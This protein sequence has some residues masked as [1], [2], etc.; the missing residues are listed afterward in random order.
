MSVA[1][2]RWRPGPILPRRGIP[3]ALLFWVIAAAAFVAGLAAIGCLVA[4]RATGDWREQV[5]GSATVVVRASGLESPD[6]AAARAA[7]TLLGLQGVSAARTL[8]STAFDEVI[9]RLIAGPPTAAESEPPRLLAAAFNSR[10]PATADDLARAL[11]ADGLEAAVDDHGL[12][13]SP[14]LRAAALTV[15]AIIALVAVIGAAI[16]AAVAAATRRGLARTHELA[17]LLRILGAADGFIAGLFE[18]R[19]ARAAAWAGGAGAIAAA[20]AAAAWRLFGSDQGMIAVSAPAW[21][22]LAAAAPAALI[23]ALIGAAAARLTARST[24]K[25]L[26]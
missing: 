10:P 16:G 13:T 12:W 17:Q 4:G 21:A 9:G 1:P 15:L 24:L 2:A 26:P 22:D 3:D 11:K 5:S 23:A 14:L 7:E 25:G 8:D 18:A 6:A 19:S 20:L